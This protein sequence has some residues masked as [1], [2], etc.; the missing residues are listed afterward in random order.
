MVKLSI[1]CGFAY[2]RKKLVSYKC[3]ELLLYYWK[4]EQFFFLKP[5]IER[6]KK[7]LTRRVLES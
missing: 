4:S 3:Q 5:E 1:N 2:D 6:L 7:K